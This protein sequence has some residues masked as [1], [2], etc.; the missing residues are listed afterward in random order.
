MKIL[1][2]T[3][4]YGDEIGGPATHTR[5][6]EESS[7][8][9]GLSI[10]TVPFSRVRHLPKV[11]RHI[12]Y[13]IHLFRAGRGCDIIYALDPV[14]VGFP[15]Y[16]A[17]A[18]LRK[19]FVLRVAGDYAWE[20][21]VGRFGCTDTL[22]V[23]RE[24]IH[25]DDARYRRIVR[26]LSRLQAFVA[27]KADAVIVPSGYLKRIVSGWGITE[28]AIT[29]VY[30]T[31]E[32]HTVDQVREEIRDTYD[33]RGDVLLSAG[34]LVSWKGFATLIDCV[35]HLKARYPN[36]LLL[37]AGDGPD[38]TALE[39]RVAEHELAS[40][41][42]FLGSVP[43]AKLAELMRGADM[44][45]LNTGYEGFSHTILEAMAAGTPVVTTNVC[46]NPELVTHEESGLLVPY[47]DQYALEE[48]I[49]CLLDDSALR[50]RMAEA[51]KTTAMT[52]SRERMLT[53]IR[54]VFNT[55]V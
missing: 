35:A 43:H 8:D 55:V 46:G 16:I 42:R 47:D 37:I 26:F 15:A 19:P 20:Q 3:G 4:L 7:A 36:L 41:V 10:S 54:D 21:A 25:T 40:Y 31:R 13:C 45:V 51:G 2:A 49:A 32:P 18:L 17:S 12:A 9:Y 5:L 48:A 52:F 22:D 11:V 44:F 6:L 23:F 28:S 50:T 29:V 24:N 33:M 30:N 1:V 27:K 53:G 38:R 34:R 14:S 39:A